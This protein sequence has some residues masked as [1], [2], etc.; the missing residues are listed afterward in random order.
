MTRHITDP[1]FAVGY[2]LLV[3]HLPAKD[4]LEHVRPPGLPLYV[5]KMVS[6]LVY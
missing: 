5:R 3:R 2:T 6:P 1:S 4:A